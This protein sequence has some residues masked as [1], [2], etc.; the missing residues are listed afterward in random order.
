[1]LEPRTAVRSLPAY[2]SVAGGRSGLTLDLNE[3]TGG[4]SPRVLA[5]LATLKT[6]DI[7]RYPDREMGERLTA[8]FLGLPTEQVLLV[9]GVDEGLQ[10]LCSA[11]L[12]EGDEAILVQP[13]FTM[14]PIYIGATGARAVNIAAGKDF[15]FPT[16]AVASAINQRTRLICIANPN[17][18]TGTVVERE[19][20]LRIAEAAPDAAVVADEAY[21]EFYGQTVLD[22]LPRYPN[23]F[24]ARTFSKAY[25]LAGMRIGAILGHERQIDYLRRLISPFNV[26]AAALACLPAAVADYEF[27]ANYVRQIVEGRTRLQSWCQRAGLQYWPSHANFVLVKIGPRHGE[28]VEAMAQH[29]I[30]VR[31]RSMDPA[32]EGCVRITLGTREQTTQLLTA[33]PAVMAEIGVTGVNA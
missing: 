20:I 29:D 26:N 31:D 16:E 11:Y 27:V 10:L 17:N 19:A 18:P 5:R 33:M 3:N 6:T 2:H 9:N 7:S 25:G 15:A 24:V 8:K 32:C 30:H 4:C 22:A 12:G 14:Y 21:F 1:M 28:F 13:T 23:L